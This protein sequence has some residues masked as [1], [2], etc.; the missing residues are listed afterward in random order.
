MIPRQSLFDPAPSTSA[1]PPAAIPA[2][3]FLP[4]PDEEMGQNGVPAS[5]SRRQDGWSAANQRRF[6]EAIAEGHGVEAACR[7]VGLSAAS[8]YAFRR[9]A[10]G[11]AFAL[12]WR[13]ASLVA[14][15]AIAETLLVRALEGQVDTYIRADGSEVTRHRHDNRLAMSLLARLDRQVETAPDADVKA[16]RLVAQEFDAYLDLVTRD[17]GPARAGLFLARR[18]GALGDGSEDAA[19]QA[20]LAPIYALAAADRFARTGVATAGEVPVDDLDPAQRAHWTAEQWARAEAA[21]MLRLAVPAPPPDEGDAPDHADDPAEAGADTAPPSQLSQ[22]SRGGGSPAGAMLRAFGDI[23]PGAVFGDPDDPAAPP[24]VWWDPIGDEWLTRFPPPDDYDGEEDGVPGD[25]DYARSLTQLEAYAIG[26][27][28][29]RGSGQS[30]AA[31]LARRD[32][33]FAAI[34]RGKAGLR[35]GLRAPDSLFSADAPM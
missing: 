5:V 9:T 8:A 33:F 26:P 23:P 21:G 11:A 16:A 4:L 31:L 3:T 29:S 17:E 1:A 10:R 7:C 28:P 18:C 22:H 6:L 14:R 12:G 32:G 27:A 25:A 34:Y 30:P 2:H 35:A 13:A 15:E 24:L 20:D 19:D